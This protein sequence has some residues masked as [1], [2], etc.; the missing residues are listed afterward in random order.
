M[1]PSDRRDRPIFI[2][3]RMAEDAADLL[4]LRQKIY[5]RNGDAVWVAGHT[6]NLQSNPLEEIRFACLE[7]IR[8][9]ASIVCIVDGTYGS[10]GVGELSILE[11][12][13]FIAAA[14][15]QNIHI[16][17]LRTND[18][19]DPR[20]VGLLKLLDRVAPGS[21]H[22]GVYTK[23]ELESQVQRIIEFE[24]A[25]PKPVNVYRRLVQFCA[26][27]RGGRKHDFDTDVQFLDGLFLPLTHRAP[28]RDA[29]DNMLDR[30]ANEDHQPTKLG[31]CWHAIRKLS[32]VPYTDPDHKAWLSAWTRVLR[33]WSQATAWYGLHGHYVLGRL[34]AVNT[35]LMINGLAG[36]DGSDELLIHGNLGARASEYFSIS[37]LVPSF[38]DRRRWLSRALWIANQALSVPQHEISGLLAIRG[39]TQLR[40]GNVVSAIAD[41][42]KVVQ[43]R[44]VTGGAPLGEAEADLGSAYLFLGR[45]CLAEQLLETGVARM[46]N[47]G[48]VAFGVRGMKKLGLFYAVTLRRGKAAEVFS[49]AYELADKHGLTGQRDQISAYRRRFRL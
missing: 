42:K 8:D 10:W 20:L 27:L 31:Y 7:R 5:E 3:S 11:L 16:L 28:D 29:V 36:Q 1:R 9:C 22:E 25:R 15:R 49:E 32:A 48:D 14:S 17:R 43:L 40:R 34:A 47:L 37:K 38:W 39:N 6:E 18:D 12:E 13:L 23:L 44:Q 46:L 41:L 4:E 35:S 21:I 2:A 26:R 24:R 45:I 19:V 33:L 30:A